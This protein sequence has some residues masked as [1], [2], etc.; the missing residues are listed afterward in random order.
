MANF[1]ITYID[2]IDGY[3]TQGLKY[4]D[5][6]GNEIELAGWYKLI[7]YVESLIYFNLA[8]LYVNQ[9]YSAKSLV[10]HYDFDNNMCRLYY[11]PNAISKPENW[12]AA[13]WTETTV[14]DY[15]KLMTT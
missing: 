8:P 9:V 13:H 15:I 1:N 2:D 5:S 3:N 10:S 12:T 11:N 6:K 14:A 4:A 7:A